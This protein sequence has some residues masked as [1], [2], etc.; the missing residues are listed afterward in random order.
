MIR[1][2][3]S[4]LFLGDR[5]TR[6]PNRL[7]LFLF[8]IGCV[9]STCAGQACTPQVVIPENRLLVLGVIA[10]NAAEDA[11][12]LQ[13]L[14]DVLAKGLQEYG[15]TGGEVRV[16]ASVDE[17]ADWMKTGVVDLYFDSAYPALLVSEQSQAEFILRGWQFGRPEAQ[18][19]IFA[20]RNSGLKTLDDL[21]GQWIAVRAPQST[22]GFFLPLAYL[23]EEGLNLVWKPG[24]DASID[25]TEAGFIFTGSDQETLRAVL[26]RTAAAGVVDDYHFDI[27]LAP[28][29]SQQ[30]VELARTEK[31]PRQ[32][33]LARPG[34]NATYRAILVRALERL[35]ETE[36]GRAALNAFHTTRFDSFPGGAE[37]TARR[38]REMLAI[39]SRIAPP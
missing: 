26:S 4:P 17:M 3:L 29:I 23:A 8:L 1:D 12:Q 18:S 38:L 14:A 6:M 24:F 10:G 15:I 20:S 34:L 30:L 39:V 19:V 28:E 32:V 25:G 33:V 27:V 13:P 35:H 7:P 2:F 16:A 31:I 37:E 22:S 5:D 21:Q 9:L 11:S 36:S